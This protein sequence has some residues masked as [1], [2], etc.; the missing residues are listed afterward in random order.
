MKRQRLKEK[1]HKINDLGLAIVGKECDAVENRYNLRIYDENLMT[2]S[3]VTKGL[4]GLKAEIL[5]LNAEK[6]SLF[7][8]DLVSSLPKN[9]LNYNSFY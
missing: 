4:E 8:L 3:L 5:D 7:P 2:F 6:R 9:F 1:A